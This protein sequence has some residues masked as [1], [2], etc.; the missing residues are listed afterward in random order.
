MLN[1]AMIQPDL[2]WEDIPGN[3][4]YLEA[5]IREFNRDADIILLPELFSTGFTMRSGDLAERMDGNTV[6]WMKELAGSSGAGH[7]LL[8]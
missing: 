5:R 3:L 8:C 6:H 7:L 1:V 4:N 2:L